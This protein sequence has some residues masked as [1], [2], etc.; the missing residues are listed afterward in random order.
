[1]AEEAVLCGEGSFL[2]GCPALLSKHTNHSQDCES[3]AEVEVQENR[4][5]YSDIL[6]EDAEPCKWK[7]RDEFYETG[8]GTGR[9]CVRC[10]EPESCS[11]GLYWK[12]CSATGN[13]ACTACPDLRGRTGADGEVRERYVDALDL[14]DLDDVVYPVVEAKYNSSQQ[15]ERKGLKAQLQS[16][17]GTHVC[18]SRCLSDA[19]RGG[20][21]MCK[22]CTPAGF[23]LEQQLEISLAG[24]GY[25]AVFPCTP[26][27]DTYAKPCPSR[28]GTRILGHDPAATGDCPR[29][30]ISGWSVDTTFSNMDGV[31][32]TSSCVQCENVI[33][34]DAQY[35]T[36][37]PSET[38]AGTREDVFE[39]SL[40]TCTLACRP[41]YLLLRERL[42]WANESHS[43][44]PE[45]L[46][47]FQSQF[48]LVPE[49]TCVR[50]SEDA[51]GVGNYPTGILCE[52]ALCEMP[53]IRD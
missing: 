4:A 15:A 8:H 33:S 10:G 3:C 35:G 1:L 36:R 17:N 50:C 47:L 26:G 52:C 18:R 9:K 19:F 7:C 32:Y 38:E 39:F 12:N 16:A 49:R 41:P 6:L 11:A 5:L 28:Q 46:G 42:R 30:C 27:T 37:S 29:E 43:T 24:D 22:R 14:L 34:I 20:D 45:D 44:V 21:G 51:C 25:F 31:A 13:S 23:V 48:Q 2:K 53:D 40:N